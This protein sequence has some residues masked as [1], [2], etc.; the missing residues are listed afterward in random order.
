MTN[1]EAL[2]YKYSLNKQ[3]E[4]CFRTMPI[5]EFWEIF[6]SEGEEYKVFSIFLETRIG[7]IWLNQFYGQS[8]LKWQN[9]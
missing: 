3:I 2:Q 9:T 4:I 8:Y 1:I 7:Q 6:F 5:D